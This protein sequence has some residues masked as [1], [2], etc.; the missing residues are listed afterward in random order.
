MTAPAMLLAETTERFLKALLVRLPVERIIELHLFPGLRQGGIESGVA[1]V[2]AVPEGETVDEPVGAAEAVPISEALGSRL[3]S[4]E[5]REPSAE[6]EHDAPEAGDLSPADVIAAAPEDADGVVVTPEGIVAEVADEHDLVTPD[7]AAA[8]VGDD[9]EDPAARAMAE[10]SVESDEVTAA[11]PPRPRRYTIYTAHYRLVLKGPERGRW[12]VSVTA[13][14][15]APLLTLEAV[16]RGVQ[17]R[18]GDTGDPERLTGGE[19]RRALRLPPS[20]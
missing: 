18:A 1:V 20:A 19:L 11:A 16:V 2:A 7:E 3:S 12:E 6:G 17:R 5:S 10:A 14:A 13:E 8:V 4:A 9:V 15:D